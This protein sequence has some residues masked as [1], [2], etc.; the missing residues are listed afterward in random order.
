M[1][2][3]GSPIS[4]VRSMS[5]SSSW[6]ACLVKGH[7]IAHYV[8]GGARWKQTFEVMRD[9]KLVNPDVDMH[10]AYTL[11]FVKKIKVLP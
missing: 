2:G 8:E 5:P 4:R 1:A 7:A 11:E 6:R 3:M 10:K 9:A